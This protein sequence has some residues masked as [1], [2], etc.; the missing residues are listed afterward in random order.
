MGK[1]KI[2]I[3]LS[4]LFPITHSRKGQPTGY[5]ELL[6]AGKKIHTIRENYDLWKANEEK[7]RTGRY[8]LSVRQWSG[9]PYHSK[10]IEVAQIKNP[11]TVQHIVINNHTDNEKEPLS[12]VIEG[13]FLSYKDCETLAKNDGLNIQDFRELFF[14]Q[15]NND[16]STF[17]GC[18]I[19]FTDFRY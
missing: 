10:Q 6:N 17:E 16:S 19:H 13:T 5:A 14:G 18:I 1:K 11:I 7:M 15:K 9:R 4:R 2:I 3:T 12:A 8:Y